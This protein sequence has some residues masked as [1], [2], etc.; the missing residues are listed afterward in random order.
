MLNDI[1]SRPNA[2]N[3]ASLLCDLF[4]SFGF[5]EVWVNQGGGNVNNFI[6]AIKQRLTDTFYTKLEGE[7]RRINKS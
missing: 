6:Y 5:R 2:L 3:W 7:V 1:E 4:S